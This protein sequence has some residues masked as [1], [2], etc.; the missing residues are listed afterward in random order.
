MFIKQT[1]KYYLRALG[2]DP[3][4]DVANISIHFPELARDINIPDFFEPS[5]FFSSVFRMASKGT[6]L[7]THYDVRIMAN[8]FFLNKFFRLATHTDFIS[9]LL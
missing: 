9:I 3:R 6:Q 4:K 7:W 2:D 1:E 5:Q 8:F